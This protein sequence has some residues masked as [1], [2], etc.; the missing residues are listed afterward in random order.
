MV[1]LIPCDILPYVHILATL[2][3]LNYNRHHRWHAL[4][5]CN[6]CIIPFLLWVMQFMSVNFCMATLTRLN[7]GGEV[8]EQVGYSST[9]TDKESKCSVNTIWL[10]CIYY[11]YEWYCFWLCWRYCCRMNKFGVRVCY[12][13]CGYYLAVAP[14]TH[15]LC[16]LIIESVLM[17][18]V[19]EA[20]W[21]YVMCIV[22]SMCTT[23]C[24]KGIIHRW[25]CSRYCSYI[26]L[27]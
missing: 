26:I 14:Q 12:I 6:V 21:C 24:I 19:I 5:Q 3:L 7:R 18:N 16:I 2:L 22:V 23:A 27:A 4:Q 11:E 9:G 15:I 10:L 17:N 1:L 13:V 20:M 8:C 25:G